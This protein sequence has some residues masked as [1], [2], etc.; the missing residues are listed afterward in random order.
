MILIFQEK[1]KFFE[2]RYAKDYVRNFFAPEEGHDHHDDD[3]STDYLT[4]VSMGWIGT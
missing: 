4:R 2:E 1:R 3:Q